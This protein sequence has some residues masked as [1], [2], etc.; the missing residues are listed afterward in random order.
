MSAALRALLATG[1]FVRADLWT[2]TLN[3]GVVVRWTS[4]DQPLTWAG[5]TFARGPNIE[6]GAIS[7]KRG[8]EVATLDVAITAVASDLINGT[9][10]IPFIARHGLDGA[11]IKLERCYAANWSSAIVGTV[12]RFAGKVTAINSVQGAT[13]TLTVSSWTVLLNHSAPRNLYQGGCLRTLYDTGC[14]LNP[15]S[16]SATAAVTVAGAGSFTSLLTA[17]EGYYNQGR[18]VFT[19][20]ANAGVSRTVKY[21]YASGT[22]TLVTPLPVQ[23][24]VGDTFIAYAGCD[25]SRGTCASKF[26]NLA[27]HKATPFVPVPTTTLGA[28]VTTTTTGGKG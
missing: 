21:S 1:N 12:L 10:I 24:A 4:H 7:E 23:A 27:R 14:A 20:G 15:A 28:A 22:F 17:A 8:V 5:Q 9:A 18:V 6:R 25:L 13:A 2:I 3:G 19:S 11:N 16:F 26:N